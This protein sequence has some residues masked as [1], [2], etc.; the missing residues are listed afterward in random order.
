MLTVF[1]YF[2][3]T[4]L[5]FLILQPL[6]ALAVLP[7]AHAR[8]IFGICEATDAVL[9]AIAPVSLVLLAIRPRVDTKA[10]FLVI[11]VL[12]RIRSTIWPLVDAQAVEL[13]IL[14]LTGVL[15]FVRRC[16]LAVPAHL[17][18]DPVALVDGLVGPDVAALAMLFALH[19]I[20]FVY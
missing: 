3:Q 16:E 18:I 1:V 9:E 2:D 19:E 12:A 5:F 20:A 17:V 11:G 15:S 14:I 7:A 6:D 10:L 13:T 4:I 8:L